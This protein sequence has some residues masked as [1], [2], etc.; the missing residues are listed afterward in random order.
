MARGKP[1]CVVCG[2]LLRPHCSRWRC[3]PWLSCTDDE[4]GAVFNPEKNRWISG[5]GRPLPT[6]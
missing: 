3:A 1:L 2:A 4:C 5:K 6:L